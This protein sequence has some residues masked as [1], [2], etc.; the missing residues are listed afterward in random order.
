MLLQVR[1]A[2]P[3]SGMFRSDDSYVNFAANIDLTILCVTQSP[4]CE[5]DGSCRQSNAAAQPHVSKPTNNL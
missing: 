4:T 2:T 5:A 1:T 3:N